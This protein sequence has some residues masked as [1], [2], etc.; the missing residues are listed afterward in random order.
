MGKKISLWIDRIS[1][2]WVVLALLIFMILF[3][4]FVLPGQAESSQK[5][6]GI[7][8]DTTF[9]YHPKELINAAEDYGSDGRHFYIYNRW[10]FDLIFPLVYVGFL[11]TGI[12]WYLRNRRDGLIKQLNLLPILAGV[13]DYLENS[14][15]TTVMALYPREFY[16]AAYLAS[17]F[18]L[19]KWILVYGSFGVYFLTLFYYLFSVIKNTKS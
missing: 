10:T 8:P 15:T 12:S 19:I 6:S 7:S 2:G 4:I 3:M 5:Y 17:A 11:S 9:F 16:P 18:T 1:K 13:F 14:A